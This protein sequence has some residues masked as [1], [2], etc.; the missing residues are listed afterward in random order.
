MELDEIDYRILSILQEDCRISLSRLASKA[1]IS[2]PTARQRIKKLIEQGV[3]RRFTVVL[4]PSHLAGGYDTFIGIS[5]PPSSIQELA[6]RLKNEEEVLGVYRTVGEYDLLLRLSLTSYAELDNFISNKLSKHGEV[7]AIKTNV[8]IGILKDE[9]G[10][11]LRP[12]AGIKV[13]CA[14][15]GKEIV[16]SPLKRIVEG[17]TY[18]LCCSSCENL[19]DQKTRLGRLP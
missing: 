18:Y 16:G 6:E 7:H 2:I 10:P 14:V 12:G 1:R 3:I 9:P 4:D 13:Y 19:F 11:K 8:V 15:C 5:A 17:K